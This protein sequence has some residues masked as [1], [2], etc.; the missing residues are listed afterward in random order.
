[1]H[2]RKRDRHLAL[3][4]QYA[5]NKTRM[6]RATLARWVKAAL[7]PRPK[8]FIN[9]QITLRFVD[10]DEARYLNRT[11][12]GKDEATN[13]LT[14]TYPKS[15]NNADHTD[16]AD[17]D[18]GDDSSVVN[19][20]SDLVL[21]CPLIDEEAAAQNKALDA[22]YAHLVV[23]GMLH[24]QGYDHCDEAEA[25]VMEALEVEILNTLGFANPYKNPAS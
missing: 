14:F 11:Y 23:H 17:S 9:A 8:I 16:Y 6:P 24:A 25:M 19:I 13:I 18:E 20:N 7:L 15:I 1:M 3:A 21:C 4:V 12:R 22:H 2:A 5:A 10:R